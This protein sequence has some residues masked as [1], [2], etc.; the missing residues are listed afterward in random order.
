[1]EKEDLDYLSNTLYNFYYLKRKEKK[2][3]Q[4]LIELDYK[5]ETEKT[6]I[7]ANAYDIIS[8]GCSVPS[9]HP[10]SVDYLVD[11]Q[12]T[13][14]MKISEI[15]SKYASLDRENKITERIAK[16]SSESQLI[17]NNVF[18]RNLSIT[19]IATKVENVSKQT[20]SKRLDQALR[21]MLKL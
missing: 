14:A 7:S 5:I 8:S 21:E 9:P 6:Y 2:Y 10:T 1:M 4:D 11:K 19:Y 17:I 13:I 12:L 16:L 18:E 3:N 20:I 15:Q